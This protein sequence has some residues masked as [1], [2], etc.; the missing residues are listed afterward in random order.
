MHEARDD[1][2][3]RRLAADY[4]LPPATPREE[5]WAAIEAGIAGAA[6]RAPS[7]P[8]DVVPI[9]RSR[10][11]TWPGRRVDWR[12]A[13]AA[14]I[15]L[16][17][18]VGIGRMTAPPREAHTPGAEPSFVEEPEGPSSD[19]FRVAAAEH[20]G[21]SEALLTLLREDAREG[22]LDRRVGSWG[23]SL[24]VETRLLLDSPAGVD[25]SLRELLEDLEMIL[26]QVV[27]LSEDGVE[28]GER[29]RE[30]LVLIARGVEEQDVLSRIQAAL[31]AVDPAL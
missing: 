7:A 8:A 27:V 2:R 31:P 9:E 15:V 30:E 6:S 21:A 18:G 25:P 12:W 10:T 4:N 29:G 5:M 24:L 26:A 16:A 11:P 23:R 28:D 22:R 1:E 14:G 17:L 3:L 20:L 13:A 19:P